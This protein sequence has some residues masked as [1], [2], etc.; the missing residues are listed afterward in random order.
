MGA[1]FFRLALQIGPCSSV[2]KIL[3]L[4]IA[5]ATLSF[6]SWSVTC[7]HVV[8]RSVISHGSWIRVVTI[9]GPAD[10][11]V[12]V[13]ACCLPLKMPFKKQNM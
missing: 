11:W 12:V 6:Y 1:F 5:A 2:G 8:S 10:L 13:D 3:F 9:E 7:R 4:H